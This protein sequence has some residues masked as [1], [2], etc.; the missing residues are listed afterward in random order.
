MATIKRMPGAIPAAASKIGLFEEI[1]RPNSQGLDSARSEQGMQ[2]ASDALEFSSAPPATC[3]TRR[4]S[5]ALQK[6]A[7][8]GKLEIPV[9]IGIAKSGWNLQQ[10]QERAKD[11]VEGLRR[12]GCARVSPV[13]FKTEIH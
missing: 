6:L 4:F 12:T 7:R 3:R 1:G 13:D 10:L 8:R 2:P 11:S 5:P 9:L